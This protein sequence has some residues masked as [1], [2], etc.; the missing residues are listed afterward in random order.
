MSIKSVKKKP[1]SNSPYL[2]DDYQVPDTQVA[3][4][5]F[6]AMIVNINMKFI[7]TLSN[8]FLP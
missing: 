8:Q 6:S 5:L 7:S 1:N 4:N 3:M 2:I